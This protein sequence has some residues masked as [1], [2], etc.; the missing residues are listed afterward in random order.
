MPVQ[1]AHP[2]TVVDC[3]WL[4]QVRMAAKFYWSD[5]GPLTVRLS[6]TLAVDQ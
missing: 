3:S 5:V 2:R 6:S 1:G 4:G